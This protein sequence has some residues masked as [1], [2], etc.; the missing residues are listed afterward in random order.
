MG[1]IYSERS[2]VRAPAPPALSRSSARPAR[3]RLP[4]LNA[5]KC[6]LCHKHSSAFQPPAGPLSGIVVGHQQPMCAT[7]TSVTGALPLP[8]GAQ[9]WPARMRAGAPRD[10][11]AQPA[12]PTR[13]LKRVHPPSP[14]PQAVTPARHTEP[15]FRPGRPG[16]AP[17]AIPAPGQTGQGDRG[18]RAGGVRGGRLG[19]GHPIARRDIGASGRVR[20]QHDERAAGEPR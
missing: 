12:G 1:M 9:L 6:E 8:P 19:R 4:A 7:V 18:D 15:P 20:D 14:A 3:P 5:G 16:P 17:Q 10:R 11:G 2:R 13:G